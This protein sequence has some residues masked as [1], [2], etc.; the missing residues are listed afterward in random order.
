MTEKLRQSPASN[1][2]CIIAILPIQHSPYLDSRI[3]FS[4]H[5]YT[6]NDDVKFSARKSCSIHVSTT[7]AYPSSSFLLT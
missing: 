3:K 7:I 1:V 2:I 5:F 4:L 6:H